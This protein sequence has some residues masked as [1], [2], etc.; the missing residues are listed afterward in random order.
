MVRRPPCCGRLPCAPH[1]RASSALQDVRGTV[2]ILCY[3]TRTPCRAAG[4]RPRRIP[5]SPTSPA[6]MC[7]SGVRA[8]RH[9]ASGPLNEPPG[10][11]KIAPEAPPHR[12]AVDRPAK[13]AG[14]G[15]SAPRRARISHR[16]ATRIPVTRSR[17]PTP[18][19]PCGP[20]RS[21]TALIEPGEP[22][23]LRARKPR[24]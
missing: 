8:A 14:T 6:R 21:R 19:V 11:G 10:P 3:A 2:C 16:G 12:E 24:T 15:K 22:P 5:M 9:A 23:P 13:H 20:V 7:R 4:T 1:V 17:W 18:C